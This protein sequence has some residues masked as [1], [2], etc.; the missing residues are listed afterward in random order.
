MEEKYNYYRIPDFYVFFLIPS[1]LMDFM[2]SWT[3]DP[4]EH[5]REYYNVCIYIFIGELT[6]LT[7]IS[8]IK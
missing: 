4:G 2:L 5:V 3:I 6:V 1:P 8:C 7:L